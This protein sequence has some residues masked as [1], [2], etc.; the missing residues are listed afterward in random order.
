MLWSLSAAT[1]KI[2]QWIFTFVCIDNGGFQ[3]SPAA[4]VADSTPPKCVLDNQSRLL[5]I[6]CVPGALL[7]FGVNGKATGEFLKPELL[8]KFTTNSAA[9]LA[10]SRIRYLYYYII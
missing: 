5:E 1:W 2:Q 4:G 8:S 6:G 7:Y 10:A 9:S 3:R